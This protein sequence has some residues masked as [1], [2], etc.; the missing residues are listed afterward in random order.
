MSRKH[1]WSIKIRN[2]DRFG[3]DP[4]SGSLSC[5]SWSKE[6]VI[7][8][9]CVSSIIMK[10]AYLCLQNIDDMALFYNTRKVRRT[11]FIGE[12]HTICTKINILDR[13]PLILVF[14]VR[15][16]SRFVI[17]FVYEVSIVHA[18]S[19]YVFILYV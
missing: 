11:V 6:E 8:V 10:F 15:E 4:S 17:V 16:T 3:K 9:G 13:I 1:S 2:I 7:I 14:S 5:S 19:A 12:R 18:I